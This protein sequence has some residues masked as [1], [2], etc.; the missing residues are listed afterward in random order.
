MK[1][2]ALMPVSLNVN[3]GQWRRYNPPKSEQGD[4]ED[5]DQESSSGEHN[6]CLIRELTWLLRGKTVEMPA[7]KVFQHYHW[8]VIPKWILCFTSNWESLWLVPIVGSILNDDLSNRNHIR[9]PWRRPYP[10]RSWTLCYTQGLDENLYS[11]IWDPVTYILHARLFLL[12]N[13]YLVT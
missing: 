9:T 3:W 8:Q 10:Q 4:R 6:R 13:E 1:S 12:R 2:C 11:L 7:P 5:N